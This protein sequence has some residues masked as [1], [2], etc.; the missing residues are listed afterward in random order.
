MASNVMWPIAKDN[1]DKYI[2]I[3]D[4]YR[5]QYYFCLECNARM[6][7][8]LGEI[9]KHHFAHYSG[10]GASCGGE[11]TYHAIAKHVLKDYLEQKGK[12][13]YYVKCPRCKQDIFISQEIESVKLEKDVGKFVPDLFIQTTDGNIIY[14]EVIYKHGLGEKFGEYRN[15]CCNLIIWFIDDYVEE[16]PEI[17]CRLWEAVTSERELQHDDYDL[18]YVYPN[19]KD[20]NYCDYYYYKK[21]EK[22]IV[23]KD[24]KG[25]IE[26]KE[27]INFNKSPRYVRRKMH[28]IRESQYVLKYEPEWCMDPVT[29]EWLSSVFD[30]VTGTL[31][32]GANKIKEEKRIKGEKLLEPNEPIII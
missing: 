22:E 18:F 24:R 19:I 6:I 20:H 27:N 29:G 10:A 26:T 17:D 8:K 9:K 30:D 25:S 4:A 7:A 12:I 32:I 31:P 13:E 21:I 5:E 15:S 11:G 16:V 1:N 28:Y 3:N 2:K 14:G 23:L